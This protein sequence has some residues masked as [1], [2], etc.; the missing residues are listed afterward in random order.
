MCDQRK[1]YE[2]SGDEMDMGWRGEKKNDVRPSG[3]CFGQAGEVLEA[4]MWGK[5]AK[6]EVWIYL[7]SDSWR[8]DIP[9]E[10]SS[11]WTR[12][13]ISPPRRQPSFYKANASFM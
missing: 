12:A 5:K 8:G 13:Y 9:V 2:K 7:I 4:Q 10:M 1:R 3:S 11:R 6:A